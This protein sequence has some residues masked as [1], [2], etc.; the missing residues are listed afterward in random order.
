MLTRRFRRSC[1]NNRG[2]RQAE[3][4][5]G[6]EINGEIWRQRR[7][8][9]AFEEEE[10]GK[11]VLGG[12]GGLRLDSERGIKCVDCEVRQIFWLLSNDWM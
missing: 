2:G 3:G 8:E 1:L 12:R 4:E 6:R 9:G 7:R 5:T 11:D 10:G